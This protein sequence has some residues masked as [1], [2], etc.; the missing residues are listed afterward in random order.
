MGHLGEQSTCVHLVCWALSDVPAVVPCAAAEG[1]T[2][3]G[4]G[5]ELLCPPMALAMAGAQWRAHCL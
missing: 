4:A 1:R 3:L 5:T 2:S